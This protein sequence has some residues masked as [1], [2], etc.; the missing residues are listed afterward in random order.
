MC[1]NKLPHRVTFAV[2]VFPFFYVNCVIFLKLDFFVSVCVMF[3]SF[4][5]CTFFNCRCVHFLLLLGEM[6]RGTPNT[7]PATKSLVR[8]KRSKCSGETPKTSRF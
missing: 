7:R 5:G 2:S 3:V 4:G 6:G 8:E 1:K